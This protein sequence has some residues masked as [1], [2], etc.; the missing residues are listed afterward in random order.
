MKTLYQKHWKLLKSLTKEELVQKVL[1]IEFNKLYKKVEKDDSE[2][3][4]SNES[5]R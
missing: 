5:K 1:A 3:H 4:H 2:Y